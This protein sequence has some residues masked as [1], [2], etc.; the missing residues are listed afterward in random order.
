MERDGRHQG[1]CVIRYYFYD[2]TLYRDVDDT[3]PNEAWL[4]GEWK[5]I[6]PSE[7]DYE[8]MREIDE[9]DALRHQAKETA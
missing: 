2:S 1:V 4:D 5:Q 8:G 6:V 9:A 3:L 7:Q